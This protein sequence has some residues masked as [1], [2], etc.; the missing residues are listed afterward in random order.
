MTHAYAELASLVDEERL[1]SRLVELVRIPSVN[2]FDHEL[3]P[4]EGEA[5]VAEFIGSQLSDLDWEVGTI[6]VAPGRPNVWGVG[7]GSDETTVALAGHLDTV[8]VTNFDDPFSGAVRSGRVHGRGSCDMKAALAAY[9][10]VATVLTAAEADL[11][12]RVVIAGLI[13]EEYQLL[14]SRAYAE[15][16]PAADYAII[17]EPTSLSVCTAHLGQFSLVITT[18]GRAAHSSIP[19]QG[20]N[21]IEHMAR[22]IEALARYRVEIMGRP[23]HAM[24]GTGRIS[25]G[26]ISGGDIVAIVPDQCRLEIDRRITPDDTRDSVIADLHRHLGPLAE[27]DPD[28]SYDLSEPTWDIGSLDTPTDS[29]VVQAMLAGALSLGLPADPVAFPAATDGPNLGVPSV[30]CGPGAI[31]RAHTADEYVEIDEVV[32]SVHLYLHAIVGLLG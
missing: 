6:D 13:D 11:N 9:L 8:G 2:P 27:A 18:H 20:V 30:I 25:P 1:I 4:D 31:A 23:E 17:G 28:F 26:V 16:G 32:T 14:G 7:P 21:A 12:G 10:E 24:C 19:E 22:V 29:P 5:G 15:H 3:G